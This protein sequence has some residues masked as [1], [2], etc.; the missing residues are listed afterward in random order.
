VKGVYDRV[1]DRESA[2]ELLKARAAAATNSKQGSKQAPAPRS[3]SAAR[4]G[5]S[6][7]DAMTKSAVRTIGSTLGREIVRGVLGSLLGKRR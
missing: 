2:Y 5:D 4:K 3:Q 6:A 1:Q 7:F